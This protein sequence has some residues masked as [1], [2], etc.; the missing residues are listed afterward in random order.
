M[1]R[2]GLLNACDRCGYSKKPEI[3]GVHHK[4]RDRKNNELSNLEIS[5]PNCHS[6]EH[7]KHI[8]HA[9]IQA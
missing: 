5:C 9:P 4:D 1:L 2:R 7:S 8:A 6:E 3:L